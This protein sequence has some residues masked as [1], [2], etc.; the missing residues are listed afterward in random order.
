MPDENQ[1]MSGKLVLITGATAG[2]G[3]ATALA[4][5]RLGAQVVIHGRSA[6]SCAASIER[7]YRLTG[8]RPEYLTADLAVQAEVRAL[9]EAYRA[10]YG[11][12]DVLINNAGTN[13]LRRRLTPDGLELVMAVNHL[14]PFLLTH[15]LIDVIESSAPARIINVAS[16]FHRAAW[17]TFRGLQVG[18]LNAYPLSKLANIYFTYELARRLQ[19]NGVTINALDPGLVRSHLYTKLKFPISQ[20]M[21]LINLFGVPVEEGARTSV[22]LASSPEVAGVSGRYFH[23]CREERSA[24]SSYNRDAALKMW[25]VSA[26]LTGLAPDAIP[27]GGKS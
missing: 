18:G 22:Y 19:G 16:G 12:L 20:L 11:R 5:T 4:L 3:E 9:A 26:R 23:R 6:E 25:Q 17:L 15:L 7:I 14:A 13:S 8:A 27:P 24:R 1:T 2:I 10:R 21:Q